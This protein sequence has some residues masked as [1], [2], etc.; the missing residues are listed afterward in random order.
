MNVK[1]FKLRWL[2]HY[3]E[4]ELLNVPA[5]KENFNSPFIF[6]NEGTNCRLQFNNGLGSSPSIYYSDFDEIYPRLTNPNILLNK[7]YNFVDYQMNT[8]MYG[9]FKDAITEDGIRITESTHQ[10]CFTDYPINEFNSGLNNCLEGLLSNNLMVDDVKGY[11]DWG[12]GSTSNIKPYWREVTAYLGVNKIKCSLKFYTGAN[13]LKHEYTDNKN[14][15]IVKIFGTIPHIKLPVTSI[16][17]IDWGNIKLRSLHNIFYD[18]AKITYI[19]LPKNLQHVVNASQMFYNNAENINNDVMKLD[20]LLDLPSLVNACYILQY[21]GFSKIPENAFCKSKFLTFIDYGFSNM[22]NPDGIIIENNVLSNC[23]NLHSATYLCAYSNIKKVGNS[24][25]KN[26][27]EIICCCNLFSNGHMLETIGDNFMENCTSC[28]TVAQCFFEQRKLTTIGNN[29]FKNCPNIR[30]VYQLFYNCN[31]LR[32]IPEKLF[33]DIKVNPQYVTN[34]FCFYYFIDK[35]INFWGQYSSIEEANNVL[36]PYKCYIGNNMFNPEFFLQGGKIFIGTTVFLDYESASIQTMSDDGV[37]YRT[38]FFSLLEG[39]VPDLWNYPDSVYL[40]IFR[41]STPLKSLKELIDEKQQIG[42]IGFYGNQSCD[43][44][45]CNG[46]KA[47][48]NLQNYNS[49]P[50]PSGKRHHL[51]RP[52]ADEVWLS[53]MIWTEAIVNPVLGS[54]ISFNV[55]TEELSDEIRGIYPQYHY[56]HSYSDPSVLYQIPYVV[57]G[58]DGI[59]SSQIVTTPESFSLKMLL[60]RYPYNILNN[61]WVNFSIPTDAYIQGNTV[62]VAVYIKPIIMKYEIEGIRYQYYDVTWNKT[63]E[64]ITIQGRCTDVATGELLYT[65]NGIRNNKWNKNNDYNF[66]QQGDSFILSYL[67]FENIYHNTDINYISFIGA[68]FYFKNQTYTCTSKDGTLES[69]GALS[70]K[71]NKNE[72]VQPQKILYSKEYETQKSSYDS[73]T[74]LQLTGKDTGQREY[75]KININNKQISDRVYYTSC[76]KTVIVN[77]TYDNEFGSHNRIYDYHIWSSPDASEYQG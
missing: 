2:N 1:Q 52:P 9:V 45:Y 34:N 37:V 19:E 55:D 20:F 15:H 62:N 26:C 70:F 58:N 57:K 48:N 18:C 42:R 75:N 51:T 59:L 64:D 24:F 40:Q 68:L 27:V 77:E 38:A 60:C 39:Y 56:A 71:Y 36:E 25:L 46:V 65:W 76:E 67:N 23:I 10:E 35:N 14:N 66:E 69:Y 30:S 74:M 28:T 50:Q 32:R 8:W 5:K 17:V 43:L 54:N 4:P 16:K 13:Y 41:Q 29:M 44:W 12:D 3:V 53:T 33:Y 11:I 63:A 21:T 7:C 61:D 72:L 6:E 73:V 22:G 31:L 49:I 47:I